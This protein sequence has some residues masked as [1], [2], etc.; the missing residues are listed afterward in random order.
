MSIYF[1]IFIIIILWILIIY[2][3]TST[4][5]V[6]NET[7]SQAIS[8][9][10]LH[11]NRIILYKSSLLSELI[12]SHPFHNPKWL[13]IL[14]PVNQNAILSNQLNENELNNNLCSCS[15]SVDNEAKESI[16]D[17]RRDMDLLKNLFYQLNDQMS[18]ILASQTLKSNNLSPRDDK[19]LLDQL[20][21]IIKEHCYCRKEGLK[22]PEILPPIEPS[23][24]IVVLSPRDGEIVKSFAKP[25]P[26]SER[27][28]SKTDNEMIRPPN[29][30][31]PKNDIK[32]GKG[33]TG[34]RV[35]QIKSSKKKLSS[36]ISGMDL[37]EEK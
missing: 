8:L 6:Y 5:E 19:K 29:D 20:T 13:Q 10:R 25:P 18:N 34:I 24:S 37:D 22:V 28:L 35:R 12:S 2:L 7:E 21:D 33:D 23:E 1:P 14:K 36:K 16:E 4:N 31:T 17:I 26:L 15:N 32:K 11:Q 9:W 30:T 27:A 3:I